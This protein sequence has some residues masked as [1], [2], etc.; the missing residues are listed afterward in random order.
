[1]VLLI[2][3]WFLVSVPLV[4]LGGFIGYKKPTI[5]NPCK[6]YPIPRFVPPQPWYLNKYFCCA[7][8]G[9]LPFGAFFIELVFIMISIWKHSFY[10]LFAFLFLVLLILLITCAEISI[11]ITYLQLCKFFIIFLNFISPFTL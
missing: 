4:F 2:A 10:Y 8:G 3:L 1:M 9:L 5:K 11:V 6:S 7:F